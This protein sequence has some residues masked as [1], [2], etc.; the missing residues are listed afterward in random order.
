MRNTF[1][2]IAP[3]LVAILL[4]QETYTWA[5]TSPYQLKAA[6]VHKF[7]LFIDYPE[8][9]NKEDASKQITIC[10]YGQNPFKN[11]FNPVIGTSIKGR[12]LTVKHLRPNSKVDTLL[13][14][15]AIFFSQKNKSNLVKRTLKKVKNQPILTIGENKNF[16]KWGGLIRLYE[17]ENRT[18]FDINVKEGTLSQIRFRSQMLR[19][20]EN[21]ID[22]EPNQ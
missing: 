5:D 1:K 4:L 21:V 18:V 2:V 19:I 7:L 9:S 11:F 12:K 20:A 22:Y 15:Q 6:F 16:L 10:I 3:L 14:C 13:K 8:S 17:F